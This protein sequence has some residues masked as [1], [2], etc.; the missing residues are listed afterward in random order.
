MSAQLQRAAVAWRHCP[1]GLHSLLPG[2][3]LSADAA[4]DA[5]VADAGGGDGDAGGGDGDAGG[6]SGG[7][8]SLAGHGVSSTRGG[9]ASGVER[10]GVSAG[11]SL[12]ARADHSGDAGAGT[13]QQGG[14][15]GGAH[16]YV[17]LLREPIERMM[18]W[19]A[20]C[21]TASRDYCSAAGRDKSWHEARREA[22]AEA[23]RR[24]GSQ[25]AAFYT[26]RERRMRSVSLPSTAARGGTHAPLRLEGRLDDNY[27]TR[28]LCGYDAT[29]GLPGNDAFGL[30]RPRMPELRPAATRT[31]AT[32]SAPP[33]ASCHQWTLEPRA[34]ALALRLPTASAALVAFAV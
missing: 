27:M 26:V 16:V 4:I 20:W 22:T 21:A 18:S 25:L 2:G 13:D 31:R 12:A 33:L 7:S 10:V 24:N 19:Q 9:G 34:S 6:E 23:R 5:D 11:G 15:R 28:M 30:V 29:M 8:S 1:H 3:P 14:A 17:T 32:G